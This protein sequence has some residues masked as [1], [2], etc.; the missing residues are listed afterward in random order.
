[1]VDLHRT[2]DRQR[3]ELLERRQDRQAELDAGAM[4]DFPL[5]TTAVRE[6]D[7]RVAPAPSI[8]MTGV[9]RCPGLPS[10]R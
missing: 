4:P 6:A 10:A 1:M 7:W 5:A 8:S 9:S 3:I 2:F